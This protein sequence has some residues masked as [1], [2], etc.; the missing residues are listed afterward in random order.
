MTDHPLRVHF[1]DPDRV[2]FPDPSEALEDPNGLLALGGNL[3]PETLLAAYRAGIFPWYEEHQP[4]LWWSPDP[5]AVLRLEH[6]H[7]SRSLRKTLRQ[8]R[9]QITSDT[10]FRQVIRACA[11]R[12][13]PTRGTWITAAMIDAYCRLH[14][15]GHA[16]SVECWIDGELAG[17]LYGVAVGGIFCGESM[18]SRRANASK[19]AL[20]HLVYALRQVGF[21]LV[22]CQVGNE[23]L[24]SL[25][26]T[27]IRRKDFLALLD[28]HADT[29]TSWPQSRIS[30]S[31]SA[32]HDGTPRP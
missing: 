32:N 6:I 20:V 11:Q 10:A 22:D 19:I 14:E 31:V 16:H 9:Y 23:H 4:I 24:F 27:M 8:G 13:L 12:P 18:F 28:A 26:A 1:L 5:R 21:A 2:Q 30:V 29:T 7:I 25:G 15:L 3:K 17:G